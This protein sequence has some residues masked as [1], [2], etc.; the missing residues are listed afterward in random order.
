M[1]SGDACRTSCAT[2]SDCAS[3]HFCSGTSCKADALQV[4]ISS[5]HAC[6]VLAD[7]TVRC[8]GKN[9]SGQLGNTL[10]SSS[11][12]VQ[13]Q[14]ITTVK[15]V[16]VGGTQSLAV[17]ANG[18]VMWWGKRPID[19][20][21]SG[22][23]YSPLTPAPTR[24][25]GL[26]NAS[27]IVTAA[28]GDG[29]RCALVDDKT[30]HC[31][32]FHVAP[33]GDTSFLSIPTDIGLTGVTAISGGL[34]FNCAALSAGGAKCWGFGVESQALGT[35][36]AWAHTPVMVESLTGSVSKLRS[37]DYF[38]CVMRSAG[39]VQC[40][41]SNQYHQLGPNAGTS[42]SSA[43]PFVIDGLSSVKDLACGGE[44]ACAIETGG[45]IKC[46]GD[47]TYG[48]LG[49]GVT[50]VGSGEP[51]SVQGLAGPATAVALGGESVC[52]ILQNGSVQC[53]GR[54]IGDLSP[55]VTPIP[56]TVW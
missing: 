2:D 6:L 53:W 56:T 1:C 40:W 33:N 13:V 3:D 49:D 26:G 45:A 11:T 52:A 44:N 55:L 24:I 8:W 50:G 5:T 7:G 23:T 15:V 54:S 4:S 47:D 35:G 10:S 36:D 20:S 27:D 16:A 34:G 42:F 12:P 48:Q 51:S 46:W 41:G 17:L 25:T 38:T 28:S 14:N 37:G 29:P 19:Y 30:A 39:D 32:G 9:D 31:W 21:A 22:T 18:Q 43:T